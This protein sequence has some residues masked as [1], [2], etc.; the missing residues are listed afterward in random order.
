[1]AG[2]GGKRVGSGR[3]PHHEQVVKRRRALLLVDRALA[4]DID[5][6]MPD[7]ERRAKADT[8]LVA[9]I[10]SQMRAG[11]TEMLDVSLQVIRE[12]DKDTSEDA[13]NAATS[14]ALLEALGMQGGGS[15]VPQQSLPLGLPEPG[16]GMSEG[17]DASAPDFVV[18]A[19]P[20]Q[21][22][23]LDAFGEPVPAAGDGTPVAAQGGEPPPPPAPT[24]RG[25]AVATDP[26]EKNS[27]GPLGDG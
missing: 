25:Y 8:A 13:R 11:R 22:G 23:L 7:E 20:A 12:A 17:Y 2:W 24:P 3:K 18:A 6:T 9:W 14:S 16:A 4:G 10:M 27:D 1:M 21:R 19:A 26:H 15:E 5:G